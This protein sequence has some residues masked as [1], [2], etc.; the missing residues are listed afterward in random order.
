[1]TSFDTTSIDAADGQMQPASRSVESAMSATRMEAFSDG[2][3]G[4]IITIMVLDLK[5]PV[6]ASPKALIADWPIFLA[7]ALSFT[8]VAIY[9]IN[10][11]HLLM[12]RGALAT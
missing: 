11:H 9:W 6:D 5:A 3:I 4:I 7:Y 12:L 10:H 2:V 8:I 1:M